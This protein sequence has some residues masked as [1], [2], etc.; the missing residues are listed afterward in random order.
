M[1]EANGGRP[2]KGRRSVLRG[3][4]LDGIKDENVK[5]ALMVVSEN[6]AVMA[7]Q[8]ERAERMSRRQRNGA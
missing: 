4:P 8:F 1:S 3:V 5:R 7:A 2:T 6:M